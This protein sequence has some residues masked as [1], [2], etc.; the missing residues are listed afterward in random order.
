MEGEI[1]GGVAIGPF[2]RQEIRN[3]AKLRAVVGLS[4]QEKVTGQLS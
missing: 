2:P 3:A 1:S 4:S